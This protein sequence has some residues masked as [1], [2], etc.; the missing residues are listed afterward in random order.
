MLQGKVCLVTGTRSGIGKAI[1]IRF[2]EEGAVV[3]ANAKKEE[4]VREWSDLI[5]VKGKII[6]LPFDVT[7][8]GQVRESML[9][10]KRQYGHLDV[11]VNNAAVVSYEPM[12]M[13]TRQNLESMFQ[14]NVFAVFEMMQF[15]SR[16][17]KAQSKGSIINISSMVGEKGAA[18]QAAY[19]MTKGAVSSLTKSAAKELAKDHIRVNAIAPGMVRSERFEKEMTKRFPKMQENILWGRLA[20]PEE[21]ADACLFLASDLSAYISGQIIGVDGCMML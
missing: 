5:Q 6:P 20:E 8:S 4:D 16:M 19:S 13:M 9:K 3:F 18:G 15:V 12:S 11:Q 17:M 14:V 21:I 2:A 10:I 1:A 7:D